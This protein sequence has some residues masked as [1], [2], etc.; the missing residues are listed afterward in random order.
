MSLA[1]LSNRLK[2]SSASSHVRRD[3]VA[4]AKVGERRR[5][6]AL[7][8]VL[9]QRPRPEVAHLE[10]AE[11]RPVVGD[12]DAER[13]HLLDRAGNVVAGAVR[14]G[15]GEA[16]VRDREVGVD[17]Q[18]GRR[19]VV[20]VPLDAVAPARAGSARSRRRRRRTPAPSRAAAAR[21][22]ASSAGRERSRV[23]SAELAALGA[24]Q[25]RRRVDRGPDAGVRVGPAHGGGGAA[26]VV[27]V[28]AVAVVDEVLGL[29][30]R[31]ED[32][33]ELGRAEA[34]PACGR[35]SPAIELVDL[36]VEAVAAQAGDAAQPRQPLGRVLGLDADAGLAHLALLRRRGRVARATVA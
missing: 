36:E 35:C 18:P 23:R 4:G 7:R 13:R 31:P 30:P 8:V 20:V 16:G 19:P 14:V 15:A 1:F 28:K 12:G 25:R 10:L 29:R 32:Q 2:T 3:L 9:D 5:L 17:Q 33:R 6:R 11:P 22:R 26:R 24:H 27:A 21:A 34:S